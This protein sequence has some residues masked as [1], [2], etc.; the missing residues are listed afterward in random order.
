MNEEELK[1]KLHQ[2]LTAACDRNMYSGW[3]AI[4][5]ILN[6]DGVSTEFFK[7]KQT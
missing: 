6:K 1:F 5:Y 7:T 2:I 4:V 3:G